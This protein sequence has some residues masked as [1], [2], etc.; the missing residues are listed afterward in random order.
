MEEGYML[1][2]MLPHYKLPLCVATNIASGYAKAGLRWLGPEP[3]CTTYWPQAIIWALLY[4]LPE[5]AID[6]WR[7]GFCLKIRKRGQLK[8]F[9]KKE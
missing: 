4:K 7:Y 8:D 6:A 1:L 3:R 2:D 9:R 5:A